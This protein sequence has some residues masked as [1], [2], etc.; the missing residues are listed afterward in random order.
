MAR[1]TIKFSL[2]MKNGAEVRSIEE[3]R[4]N[5][6]VESIMKYYFSGQLSLWCKA[7]NYEELPTI[8]DEIKYTFVKSICDTLDLKLSIDEM[9]KY[10][11]NCFGVAD[12]SVLTY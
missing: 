3:L 4:A 1:K 12:T 5:A 2:K 6:D 10:V 7:F 9:Q 8:F 11:Q